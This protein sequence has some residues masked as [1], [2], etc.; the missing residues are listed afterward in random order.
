MSAGK[1]SKKEEQQVETELTGKVILK[2]F[3]KGSKSEHDA[4]CLV[5]DNGTFV[6]RRAGANP[7]S[8]EKLHAMVGKEITSRGH[9][10][11]PYFM[12]TEFHEKK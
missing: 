2:K 12:I 10:K 1:S 9:L 11:E 8:D 7:F 3:G 6:L 4:I 5:T